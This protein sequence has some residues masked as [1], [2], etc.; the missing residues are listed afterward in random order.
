MHEHRLHLIIAIVAHS[1]AAGPDLDRHP[2]Q[3]AIPLPARRL[4]DGQPLLFGQPGHIGML[5][6]DRQLPALSQVRHESG[7]RL[8]LL[9]PD[10]MLHV[11]YMRRDPILRCQAPEHMQQA[12]GIGATGYTDHDR[13]SSH[14]KPILL[15][16]PYHLGQK[17]HRP[18]SRSYERRVWQSAHHLMA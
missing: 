17:A 10:A 8:R 11:G 6:G 7:I 4:L 15:N 9:T 13:L 16:R 12:E 5:N 14:Q 2:R 18:T 3:E 1:D